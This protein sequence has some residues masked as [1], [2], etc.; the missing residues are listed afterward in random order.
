VSS[1]PLAANAGFAVETHDAPAAALGALVFGRP[2]RAGMALFN[3][4]LFVGAPLLA[5]TV[6]ADASGFASLSLPLPAGFVWNGKLALQSL[7]LAPAAC[8]G[9]PLWASNALR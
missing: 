1:A 8:G 6:A 5:I 2:L 7:W 4:D 9:G 3:A